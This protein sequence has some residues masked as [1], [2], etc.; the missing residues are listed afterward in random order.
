MNARRWVIWKWVRLF[1]WKKGQGVWKKAGEVTLRSGAPTEQEAVKRAEQEAEA[2]RCKVETRQARCHTGRWQPP[3]PCIT[4]GREPAYLTEWL[5]GCEPD[6]KDLAN[7]PG[8][9][10][11]VGKTRLQTAPVDALPNGDAALPA[12][13]PARKVKVTR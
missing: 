3:R 4:D 1:P 11:F 10:R 5:P 7:K 8:R 2:L 12:A 13:L 6:P 9:K